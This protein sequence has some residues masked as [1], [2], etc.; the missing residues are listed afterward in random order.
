MQT[1][2]DPSVSL[3]GLAD[4]IAWIRANIVAII[5]PVLVC[6]VLAIAYL[7]VASPS[8]KVETLLAPAEQPGAKP[9][10]N[11]LAN[12]LGAGGLLGVPQGEMRSMSDIAIAVLQSRGFLIDFIERHNLLPVLFAGRWDSAAGSWH[13]TD[14]APSGNDG[15]RALSDIIKVSQ[16]E[17]TGFVTVSVEWSD[18][19]V[20][21]RWLTS[22]IDEV[23]SAIR[24]RERREATKSLDFLRN[25]LAR[26]DLNELR[27]GLYELS[28]AELQKLTLTNVRQEFALETIDPPSLPDLDDPTH[29]RKL[30]ILIGSATFGGLVGVLLALFLTA[31]RNS[32]QARRQA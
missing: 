3:V 29:P 15:Y 17:V 1:E 18:P 5:L 24:E 7:V 25:E 27:Q 32:G 28:L 4:L 22:L 6:I 14:D 13:D 19:V 26:T 2:N 21:N 31:W 10:F 9:G 12:Q 16:D 30:L 8:Y 20:A 11:Q 23:N